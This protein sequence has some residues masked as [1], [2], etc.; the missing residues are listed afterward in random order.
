M[1]KNIHFILKLVSHNSTKKHTQTPKANS[2]LMH[3]K[4]IIMIL[5]GNNRNRNNQNVSKPI[6]G[7]ISA[8]RLTVTKN[9]TFAQSGGVFFNNS[10]EF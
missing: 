1:V 4:F 8:S 7:T 2:N 6:D 5:I 3:N 10:K 9:S